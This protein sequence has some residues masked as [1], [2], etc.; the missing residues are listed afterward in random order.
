MT[1]LW[2]WDLGFKNIPDPVRGVKILL[3]DKLQY[4]LLKGTVSKEKQLEY[5]SVTSFWG[6]FSIYWLT[7]SIFHT[8]CMLAFSIYGGTVM[9]HLCF[10]KITSFKHAVALSH[11]LKT[12]H[13]SR[14][15]L[16]GILAVS[17]LL[18]L[19]CSSFHWMSRNQQWIDPCV[20]QSQSKR[21]RSSGLVTTRDAFGSGSFGH[22]VAESET[23]Y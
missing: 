10:P 18:A 21:K 8:C 13:V 14:I 9:L 16:V 1:F 12:L 4:L 2:L 6:W 19:A 3:W 17:M 20:K 23:W 11:M 5:R 15:L 7:V 22:Q